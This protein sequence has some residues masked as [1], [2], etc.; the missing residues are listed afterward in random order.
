MK[1]ITI[2]I[3]ILSIM[4][5]TNWIFNRILS[6][7]GLNYPIAYLTIIITIYMAAI[8]HNR[9]AKN[10]VFIGGAVIISNNYIT[11][12]NNNISTGWRVFE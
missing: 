10:M 11:N 4:R 2:F 6:Q 1:Y 3:S 7:R 12:M 8:K 9:I 5:Y